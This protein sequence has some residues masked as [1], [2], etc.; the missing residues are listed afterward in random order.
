METYQG[1]VIEGLRPVVYR[2]KTT[3]PI[4]V[5]QMLESLRVRGRSVIHQVQL[6]YQLRRFAGFYPGT[7]GML[8]AEDVA[9]FIAAQGPLMPRTKNN[10]LTVIRSLTNFAKR[11]RYLPKWWDE[12]D[13]LERFTEEPVPVEIY[14]PGEIKRFLPE[15]PETILPAVLLVLFA[16]VRTSEA[17]KLS[18]ADIDEA[19]GFITVSAARAKTRARRLCPVTSVLSAW[20]DK[21]A[22]TGTE[23]V[24]GNTRKGFNTA[25]R[26]GLD[27]AG[28]T[29]RRNGLRHSFVSYRLAAGVPLDQVAMEAGNSPAM[30]FRHYRELVTP[31]TARAFWSIRPEDLQE[32]LPL[33]A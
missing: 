19:R 32:E 25:L 23:R 7:I 4:I 5:E 2:P 21:G 3:V 33:A 18:W 16:G 22:H 30:I 9:A 17:L 10:W 13:R 26:K 27:R 8:G 6:Q 24:C 1:Q 14:T 11:Q 29:G 28:V 20:L 12:L 15:L 31:E